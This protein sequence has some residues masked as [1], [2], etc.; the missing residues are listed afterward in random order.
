MKKLNLQ[1]IKDILVGCTILGTGGGGDLSKG[2]QIVK[3]ALENGKEFKMLS[4]DEINDEA[5][6]VNPYYCGSVNPSNENQEPNKTVREEYDEAL[7]A[8][9]ALEEF[10]NV[11]FDGVISIEYG[12]GNT[13]S[14]MA[15]AA[16]LDKCIVDCDAAGR[17]VPELQFSTYC[18]TNQSIFPF[19]VAT[20]CGDVVIFPKVL[21]DER[22]EA[23]SRNMAVVTDNMVAM[24]DHPIKGSKLKTSVIPYA[25]SYAGTVGKAQREA[26]EKSED[27]IKKI[28]EAANGYVLFRGKVTKEG[29]WEIKDGFTTGTILINGINEFDSQDFKIWYRNENMISWKNDEV[30][31]TCPDLICVIDNKTGYPITNPNCKENDEVAVLGFKAHDL[32]RSEEG[33]KLLNPGFFGFKDIEYVPIEKVLKDNLSK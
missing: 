6:Y 2:I 21:N 22:A 13:A 23:L 15:T 1:E 30:F 9:N 8:V 32:W 26:V 17:A 12:G 5:Y 19:S 10:M 4:F 20:K 24:A 16:K 28:I 29:N 3:E 7:L 27:P 11:K 33:L 18:I 25:L 14:A 31:V